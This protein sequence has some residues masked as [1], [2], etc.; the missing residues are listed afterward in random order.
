HLGDVT[1]VVDPA[2]GSYTAVARRVVREYVGDV[3]AVNQDEGNGRV[4]YHSGVA[5]LEGVAR[6]YLEYCANGETYLSKVGLSSDDK[7]PC[8]AEDG[9]AARDWSG[10]P[11]L[12]RVA[13]LA[14][15]NEGDILMGERFLFG[16][17]FDADGDRFFLLV[18]DPFKR[19]VAV[20]SGDECAILQADYLAAEHPETAGGLFI[21]TVES[22]LAV[23]DAAAGLGF[24]PLLK[25]VGDKWI[26]L[27]AAG[28]LLNS[29][30]DTDRNFGDVLNADELTADFEKTTDEYEYDDEGFIAARLKFAVGCEETG[31]TI[32]FGALPTRNGKTLPFAAGNGLKSALNTLAGIMR[33]ADETRARYSPEALEEFYRKI[34][35]P[36]PR[37]YKRNLYVYFSYKQKLLPDDEY[38]DELRGEIRA[39]LSEIRPDLELRDVHFSQEPELIYVAALDGEGRQILGVFAR[40][41]GTE[42]KSCLYVRTVAE[43]AHLASEIEKRLFPDFYK[44][45]KNIEHPR[46][47][48]EAA[49]L[50][51]IASDDTPPEI[52]E[53][54]AMIIADKQGLLTACGELTELGRSVWEGM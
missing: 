51:A 20:L 47:K 24:T 26:L 13:E 53:E 15:E 21:N 45:L 46:A 5:D 38:S 12:A 48:E 34:A 42:D 1:A 10:Y 33:I 44:S 27:E 3:Y 7:R 4:N 19:D 18:Y 37:G 2:R 11:A 31:H 16:L 40:N 30:A 23:N 36:F 28:C 54:L 50:K 52:D 35:D 43:V 8:A 22:D 25:P 49:Y 39:A 17:I 6:I 29:T 14:V 9:Y 32:S 41:S